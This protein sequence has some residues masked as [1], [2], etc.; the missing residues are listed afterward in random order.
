MLI[1]GRLPTSIQ[2]IDYPVHQGRPN[3][4]HGKFHLVGSIPV[5]CY[6]REK[7]RSLIY[8]TLQAT[9][10]ALRAAGVTRWQLP[11]CATA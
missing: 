10:A 3:P 9:E 7:G 2:Q 1:F 4:S 11:A 6:D 8:D 5:A